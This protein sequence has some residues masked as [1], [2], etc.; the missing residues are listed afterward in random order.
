MAKRSKPNKSEAIREQLAKMP[1]AT[2][3]EVAAAASKQV[4]AKVAPALVYNVKSSQGV[5][6]K[7]GRKKVAAK[8]AKPRVAATSNGGINTALI[9][10]AA[11]LLAHAGDPKAARNALAVAEEVSKVFA[12]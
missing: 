11:V 4:G 10:E 5:A 9:K 6:K 3:A 2:A 8:A 7:R 1:N 12:K